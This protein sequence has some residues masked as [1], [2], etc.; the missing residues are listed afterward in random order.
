M[1]ALRDTG[2]PVD[3]TVALARAHN[4]EIGQLCA[5]IVAM[6][7]ESRRNMSAMARMLDLELPEPSKDEPVVIWARQRA[8]A[9]G[10][11]A[12]IEKIRAEMDEAHRAARR[13]SGMPGANAR[14]DGSRLRLP[15]DENDLAMA[16]Q[17]LLSGG[18]QAARHAAMATAAAY[19]GD[20]SDAHR[21]TRAL[22]AEIYKKLQEEG[23]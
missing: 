7:D 10:Q 3:A 20:S 9:R 14:A 4:D 18:G 17:E 8:A 6:V 12:S 15:Q 22:R 13:Q 19:P 21:S 23:R 2:E 1:T 16:R 5:V 11:V